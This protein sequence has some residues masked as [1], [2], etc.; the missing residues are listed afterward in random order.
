MFFSKLIKIER[1]Y[2]FIQAELLGKPK[3]TGIVNLSLIQWIFPTQESDWG[4]L[5]RCI[6][7]EFFTSWATHTHVSIHICA[8]IY[9]YIHAHCGCIGFLVIVIKDEIL[10]YA[11]SVS[12][13]CHCVLSGRNHSKSFLLWI[14]NAVTSYKH[15]LS[16]YNGHSNMRFIHISEL[17]RE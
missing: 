6:A 14:I 2:V 10:K 9:T 15:L 4:L 5:I 8:F 12:C 17:K 16:I 3:N 7:G 11:L 1:Y 13:I